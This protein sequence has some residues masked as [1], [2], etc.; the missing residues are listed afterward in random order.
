M[1]KR[2]ADAQRILPQVAM[3]E[4][5]LIITILGGFA[6]GVLSTLIQPTTCRPPLPIDWFISQ[7]QTLPE[8]SDA[9]TTAAKTA[10]LSVSKYIDSIFSTEA[11]VDAISVVV[12]APWGIVSEHYVGPLRSNDT[13]DPRMVNGESIYRVASLSKVLPLS[14]I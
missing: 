3:M 9:L 8:F 2:A 10:S 13:A 11:N 7:A 12:S 4:V 1:Y 6:T 5:Q 14:S